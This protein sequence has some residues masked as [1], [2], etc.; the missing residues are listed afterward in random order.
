MSWP[1]ALFLSQ[2]VYIMK[3]TSSMA[4]MLILSCKKASDWI[5]TDKK[6]Q[7]YCNRIMANYRIT[8]WRS[9]QLKFMGLSE[10]SLNK[11]TV[12]QMLVLL[13]SFDFKAITILTQKQKI[14]ISW[15]GN[16]DSVL[17]MKS[18]GRLLWF[19]FII[20]GV[21]FYPNFLQEGFKWKTEACSA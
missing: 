18:L 1:T 20:N 11:L 2:H 17:K 3:D 19:C 7:M 12:G 10:S 15:E 21:S 4:S 14:V 6:M 16:V 9:K 8:P 13:K 5:H